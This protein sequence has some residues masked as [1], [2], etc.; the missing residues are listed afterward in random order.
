MVQCGWTLKTRTNQIW[1]YY[2]VSRIAKFIEREGRTV[3]ARD[4]AQEIMESYCLMGTEFQF[5]EKKKSLRKDN[6]DSYNVNVLIPL[7][8]TLKNG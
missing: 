5:G 4:W 1:F 7:N 2:V 6:G 8:Y 3:V